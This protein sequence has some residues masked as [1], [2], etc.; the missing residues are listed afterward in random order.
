MLC[1]E[2]E[3]PAPRGHASAPLAAARDEDPSKKL[4]GTPMCLGG[5]SSLLAGELGPL[6]RYTVNMTNHE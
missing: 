5:F 2:T 4:C 3:P 6:L 1:G